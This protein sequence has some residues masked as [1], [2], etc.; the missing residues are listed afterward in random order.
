[1]KCPTC[2]SDELK[3]NESRDLE[4]GSAIRRRRECLSCESRFTTYE[5]VENPALLVVK[6]SGGKEAYSKAKIRKGIEKALEKRSFSE[7]EIDQITVKID[8]KIHLLGQKEIE[9]SLIGEIVLEEL[10]G[11]DDVA[12]M[13][14]VSVYKEFE[15]IESFKK[16]V[17]EVTSGNTKVKCKIK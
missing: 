3:V 8:R 14:F 1:M 6:R 10:K 15:D 4:E 2:G 17:E 5:R 7:E 13:R 16:E 11:V 12:Y 9:T